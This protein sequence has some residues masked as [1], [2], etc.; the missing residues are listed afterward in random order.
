MSQ[1]N[2]I[3]RTRDEEI[4][5]TS[6][7]GLLE[8]AFRDWT[9]EGGRTPR[10]SRLRILLIFLLI[11]YTG[12]KLQEVLS[13]EPADL[14]L[15]ARA[16]TYRSGENGSPRKVAISQK[17]AAEL[18]ELLRA[19]KNC[20]DHFF[21]VDPA[22]VRKKFYE[23]AGQCGF[24]KKS[25]GPE[26]LRKARA[27]EMLR[28]VPLPAVQRLLG[29]SSP[30]QTTSFVSFSEDDIQEVARL[31]V[32][33]ES[34]RRTSARNSFYGKV[35]SLANDRVQTLVELLTP[36]GDRIF[37]VITNMSSGRLGLAPGKLVTAEV[38]SPWLILER[39]DAPGASSA[40]NRLEGVV[41]R[42]T[43]GDIAV[44]CVVTLR[45]G[46]ELCAV[47]AAAGFNLLRL[48]VGEP[49][50]VLFGAYAVI[51]HTG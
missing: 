29:H 23:R 4:L 20:P 39:C 2:L 1:K 31:Y 18:E 47:L 21:A 37:S 49:V 13:L 16:V 6:R 45:D 43:S 30:N 44:E 50:R 42:V 38:K 24:D 36:A 7:L 26:M 35:L 10:L 28:N 3:V 11:R 32:E 27:V 25:G 40:E 5:D 17:L 33:R 14:D 48:K 41:S 34:G 22:H 19:A 9:G 12:A 51:L 46:T 8:R 15:Q